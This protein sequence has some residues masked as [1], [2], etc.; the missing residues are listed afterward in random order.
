MEH[1]KQIINEFI[2]KNDILSLGKK[3]K[4]FICIET[5]SFDIKIFYCRETKSFIVNNIGINNH[6]IFCENFI[7]KTFYIKEFG[8][9]NLIDSIMSNFTY[10]PDSSVK[11][12]IKNY[13]ESILNF[14][15]KNIEFTGIDPRWANRNIPYDFFK[16][17]FIDNLLKAINLIQTI[18][19]YD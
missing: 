14:R 8:L 10:L 9:T 4:F 6:K 16:D 7:P 13:E 12:T 2:L 18:I 17:K 3:N 1:F 5:Y 15:I 19:D 11:I